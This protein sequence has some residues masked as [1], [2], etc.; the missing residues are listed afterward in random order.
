M[1]KILKAGLIG[2][3]DYLRWEIDEINN[4][5]YF[6]VKSTFDLDEM[7]SKSIAK[8]INAKA[9]ESADSIFEDE[10]ISIV[11]IF[12]PPWARKEL[13]RKAVDKGKHIITTKP[14][15]SNFQ[16]SKDLA[17][18]VQAKVNC[19][20]FYGRSGNAN[21][22]QIKRILG[23]GEIGKL[24]LY[25]EDWLHHYPLWNDWATDPEKN[26]GPFMDAMV[27]NLNKSRYLINSPVKKLSFVSENYAQDLKCN[28]TEFMKI[29]FENGASSWLFITWAADL[30]VFDPTGNDRVHYGI[31]HM[32]T[33]KGWYITEEEKDG[34]PIIK[35][36]KESEVKAWE[37]EPLEYTRYDNFSVN[38]QQGKPQDF[39]YR[40]ALKD[41]EIMEE[42]LGL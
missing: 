23:S 13:F 37:V 11:M 28:D 10:E 17:E 25:K 24:A 36:V 21:V 15:G 38:L 33:D 35:A 18:I 42:S 5:R 39:D 26:G 9:V 22:E 32:I 12:T 31:L 27:H 34:K 7:K 16:D 8:K 2:C 1:T 19:A 14:F 40:D 20:V 41:M 4:S 3:G 6:K 29:D 30:E